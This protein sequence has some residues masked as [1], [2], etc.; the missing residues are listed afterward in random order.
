MPRNA[1]Q[2][3]ELDIRNFIGNWILG[4]RNYS[5]Q[6]SIISIFFGLAGSF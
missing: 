5:G 2:F 6:F 1:G 3:L 4:I